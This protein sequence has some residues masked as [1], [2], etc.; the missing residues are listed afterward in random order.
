MSSIPKMIYLLVVAATA[1][2][3]KDGGSRGDDG[4]DCVGAKCDDVDDPTATASAGDSGPIDPPDE[5][6]ADLGVSPPAQCD[7][8][9]AVLSGCLGETITDCQLEC[10]IARDEATSA[11]AECGAAYDAVLAC[12]AGLD[13]AGAADYQTAAEGYPCAV[14]EDAAFVACSEEPAAGECD[15]FCALAAM[16]DGGDAATCTALCSETLVTAEGVGADCR[17]AQVDVFACVGALSCED[18]AAWAAAEG[19][20]YPCAASDEAL[21]GACTQEG[22]G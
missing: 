16:C 3:C 10:T 7:G 5:P 8:A 9:C 17:A 6:R 21:V 4:P 12:I 18:Y 11:S 19:E 14:E 13:C 1:V 2:A 22:E 20:G 15:T